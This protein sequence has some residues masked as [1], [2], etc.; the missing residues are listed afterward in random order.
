MMKVDIGGSHVDRFR[1]TPARS[2]SLTHVK[3]GGAAKPEEGYELRSCDMSAGL[4]VFD[5]TIQETNE[6]LRAIETRLPPCDRQQAYA[7]LRATLHVLRDRLP[8]DA[9]LGL[10]AQ[11]PMLMRGLFLEGWRLSAGPARIRDPEEFI[12]AVGNH[13]PPGFPREPNAV[14]E[15]VLAVFCERVNEEE[16]RMLVR[17]MPNSLRTLW[18]AFLR[19]S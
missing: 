15:A 12:A 10:S 18:P 8:V 7:A 2:A 17:H 5:T 4:A 3:V 13:L 11:L 14:V 1:S 6:W 19:A 9:V 16:A